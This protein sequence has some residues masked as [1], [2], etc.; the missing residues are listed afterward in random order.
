MIKR[1]V[2]GL[3]TT[4]IAIVIVVSAFIPIVEEYQTEG[5]DTLQVV[6]LAGQSNIAYIPSYMDVDTVNE[7]IPKP[8]TNCY[9]Y[10][11]SDRPVWDNADL[12]QCDIHSMN[13]DDRWIIGGEECGVA[14][15]ISKK[16]SD[17]VL[18][19]NVGIPGKPIEYY[20]DNQTGGIRIKAV[21]E[22]A[23]SEI[24]GYSIVNKC[25]WVWCQ[26][27]S[28][29]TTPVQ[30]YIDSFTN[31]NNMFDSMGFERCAMVQTKPV[32]SGNSTQ[33]QSDIV[34]QFENVIWGSKAPATFTVANGL[35][36]EGN[37]LHYSQSGRD[38]VGK[39][40][41]DALSLGLPQHIRDSPIPEMITIIPVLLIASLLIGVVS[42]YVV[43]RRD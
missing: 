4:I 16:T 21:I 37:S 33:A 42:I 1:I 7:E 29:K 5:Q 11:L 18:V 6:V 3:V 43:H 39:Q 13:D 26:G 12:S 17:D 34:S 40:C 36:I 35:L 41:G 22:S 2:A 30:D 32:D 19:I 14:Y 8:S 23:L 24:T 25:G 9:F 20:Q 28:D 31:I 38:I 10:G 15:E 27:E